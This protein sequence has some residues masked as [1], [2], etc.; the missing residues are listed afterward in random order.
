MLKIFQS[1]IPVVLGVGFLYGS[2]TF[3]SPVVTVSNVV[4]I[5]T[6]AAN[7]L[8]FQADQNAND[9]T[10]VTV[11]VATDHP[12]LALIEASEPQ[13]QQRSSTRVLMPLG[14]LAQ[15][16]ETFKAEYAGYLNRVQDTL[17]NDKVSV[18]VVTVTTAVDSFVWIQATTLDFPQ[19]LGMISLN[20]FL[21]VTFGLD[22]DL[23][24]KLSN[25]IRDHW[26]KTLE[27]RQFLMGLAKTNLSRFPEIASQFGANF[28]IGTGLFFARDIVLNFQHLFEYYS[29]TEAWTHWF[30]V[31][32]VLASTHFAWSE[33]FSKTDSDLNPVAKLNLKR[34]TDLRY[35]VLVSLAS[36]S[37]VFQPE[38]YGLGPIFIL[39][40]HGALGLALLLRYDRLIAWLETNRWSKVVYEK[41]VRFEAWTNSWGR[42]IAEPALRSEMRFGF[43]A[44]QCSALF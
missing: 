12:K 6:A 33:I 15:M 37:M 30:R 17:R 2:L 40:S 18:L 8:I 4:T 21:A 27:S 32:V 26:K 1:L 28:L 16:S 13:R 25:P 36:T 20:V 5:D 44:V 42:A 31:S 43:Q 11:V 24:G 3:A 23:F 39:G 9:G 41:S 34:I 22:R 19:K 10:P 29:K 7:D 35:L 38:V 14:R